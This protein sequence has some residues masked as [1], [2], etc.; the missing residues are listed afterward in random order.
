MRR[1]Q[2][3]RKFKAYESHDAGTHH[4]DNVRIFEEDQ[5]EE[6]CEHVAALED[7]H[8][9]KC[10]WSLYAVTPEMLLGRIG[11]FYEMPFT[12]GQDAYDHAKTHWH[13]YV[14]DGKMF[15]VIE[16]DNEDKRKALVGA[17]LTADGDVEMAFYNDDSKCPIEVAED[18]L[19]PKPSHMG[20]PIDFPLESVQSQYEEE[21]VCRKCGC[22]CEVCECDECDCGDSGSAGMDKYVESSKWRMDLSPRLIEAID[23]GDLRSVDALLEAGA[24]LSYRNYYPITRAV[25][26]ARKA[27]GDK[28][29]F[30]KQTQI[31]RTVVTE[32]DYIS[33][34]AV[35]NVK[36]YLR[37]APSGLSRMVENL[38][39]DV[40][41]DSLNPSAA[42]REFGRL[43]MLERKKSSTSYK[44]SGLKHPE[45]ADL[46][47][48]KKIS[49]YEKARG[50]A[51]QKSL[52]AQKEEEGSEKGLTAAQ[53]KLPPG[54]R[55]AIMAKKKKK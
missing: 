19:G 46:N 16:T 37:D 33:E 10:R 36:M 18:H 49:G 42:R 39:S 34:S 20:D 13:Q 7:A 23:R 52:Q 40:E 35:K 15:A 50:K 26:A 22:D 41:V 12:P 14:K 9:L 47:K 8:E 53:K 44:K 45:K 25:K 2:S 21:T 29:A 54:L 1:I 38:L 30:E 51:V 11:Y 48:D 17:I 31:L 3:F 32:L 43:S 4:Q 28:A 24:D 6:F 55:K 5:H 27:I